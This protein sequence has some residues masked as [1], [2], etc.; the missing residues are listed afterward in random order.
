MTFGTKLLFIMF[1]FSTALRELRTTD[2]PDHLLN[3]FLQKN[4]CR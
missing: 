2:L 3:L 1:L 4:I